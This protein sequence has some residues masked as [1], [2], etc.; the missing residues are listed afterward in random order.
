MIHEASIRSQ[1]ND[2]NT[3][4]VMYVHRFNHGGRHIGSRGGHGRSFR[5]RGTLFSDYISTLVQSGSGN[6]V[7]PRSSGAASNPNQNTTYSQGGQ[8]Q[9]SKGRHQSNR[10]AAHALHFN[11]SKFGNIQN[12]RGHYNYCGSPFH[13]ADNYNVCKLEDHIR[14]MELQM[15]Q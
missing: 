8:V 13:W 9:I 7:F 5:G 1:S 4:E 15:K 11:P 6:Y 3:G 12:P 2:Q 10:G 14:E